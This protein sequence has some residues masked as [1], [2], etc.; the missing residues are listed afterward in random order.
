PTEL[1]DKTGEQIAKA[2]NE[3]GATTGRARRVGW[4]DATIARYAVQLNGIDSVALTKLDVLTG[5]KKIKLC[6]GYKYKGKLLPHFPTD[7]SILDEVTP[8]YEEM[9]GWWEDISVAKTLSDLPKSAYKYMQKIESLIGV[10]VS[11]L[12]VGPERSQTI[13]LRPDLLF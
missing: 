8:V 2:G 1:T 9:M 5:H 3:F 13:V 10:P 12:S 4:F 6:T 11:I 7:I